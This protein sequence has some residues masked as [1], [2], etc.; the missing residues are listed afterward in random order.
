[1][2]RIIYTSVDLVGIEIL[3]FRGKILEDINIVIRVEDGEVNIIDE[4]LLDMHSLQV[5]MHPVGSDHLIGH[6]DP[7]GLHRV[8]LVV[9]KTTDFIVIEIA[10]DGLVHTA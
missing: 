3:V 6:L 10:H 8:A 1:M 4:F 9:L 7:E 2:L 5:V